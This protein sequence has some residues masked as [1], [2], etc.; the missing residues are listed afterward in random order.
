VTSLFEKRMP[1]TRDL[2]LRSNRTVQ[3]EGQASLEGIVESHGHVV[4]SMARRVRGSIPDFACIELK[5]LVQA[6][7]VGL[8]NAVR[9]YSQD[10]GVPFELYA[11]FRIR[12]E[13]LDT[14]RKLDA[15]S[16]TLRGWQRKIRRTALDLSIHLQR[17]PTEEEISKQLGLE[18]DRLR[19]KNLDIRLASAV[20]RSSQRADRM[21]EV[22]LEQPGP[23]ESRPDA[24]QSDSERRKIVTF[25]VDQ[26]PDRPRQ[27]I[28]MYYQQE[29]TMREIG[30]IL[31]L[32]ESRISQIHK[33]ALRLIAENLRLSGIRS[34]NDL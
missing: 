16:R 34:P 26:L 28:R 14:L 25:A 17:E 29:Y 31:R 3:T 18:L 10:S 23:S 30:E 2:E 33:G 8:V 9:S 20:T 22:T 4:E 24:L 5:D 19:R 12:G 32:D 21:E 27:V 15:A 7:N 11:R 6:G 1:Q 13:M